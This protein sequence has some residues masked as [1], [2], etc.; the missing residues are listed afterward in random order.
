MAIELE[1]SFAVPVPPDQAWDVLLDVQRVAPCMPGATVDSV[2]GDEVTGKIKV[3]VGPIALTYAGK[4]T[5]TE[6]DPVNH[7]VKVRAAG[8]ETR[9]AGTATATVVAR[10]DD[11]NGQTRVNVHTS[12]NVTGRP[13]QFGRG[14]MAEVSGRIIEKFSSNLAEQ[15]GSGEAQSVL[16]NGQVPDTR[17][18]IPI[19][20]LNLPLRSFNSLKSQ[21][22]DTV[23]ELVART[24]GDLLSIK[25][26]GEKSVGE[27]EQRLG[28]LGLA[29]AGPTPGAPAGVGVGGQETAGQEAAEQGTAA[30]NG[31]AASAAW[32]GGGSRTADAPAWRGDRDADPRDS[33]DDALNLLDVAAGPI[34]R[35]ALPAVVVVAVLI[36]VATRLR[37]R[38]KDD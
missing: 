18:A 30:S 36:W 14:V 21:G 33:G 5:F 27:I 4:A 25:N 22:I 35:R 1:H 6:R 12:L 17:M 20:E 38:H 31:S 37:S 10:L 19:Q 9:G 24:P 2:E 8:K 3:K 23:G 29:L 34:L 7:S 32:D 11:D 28:D 13:A 16:P 26:L 15:L